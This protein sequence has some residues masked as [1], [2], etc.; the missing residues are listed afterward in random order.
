MRR[1]ITGDHRRAER[2][3]GLRFPSPVPARRPGRDQEEP[4]E[5]RLRCDRPDIERRGTGRIVGWASPGPR[6]APS[7]AD[8]FLSASRLVPLSTSSRKIAMT[9][10]GSSSIGLCADSLKV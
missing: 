7:P 9:L 1:A 10:S 4:G 6:A 3:S 8:Y 5:R 2:P